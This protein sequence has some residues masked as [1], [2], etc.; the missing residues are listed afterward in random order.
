MEERIE[1]QLLQSQ[2]SQNESEIDLR[3]VFG[4]VRKNLILIIIV[5][6]IFG[7]GAYFY[8][9]FFIAKQYSASATI[10]VNNKATDKAIISTTEKSPI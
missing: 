3:V 4:I 2:Q 9:S 1:Q 7:I 8:S 6:T 5:T 10:I